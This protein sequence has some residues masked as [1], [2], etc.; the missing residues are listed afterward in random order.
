MA[1][2]QI[3]SLFNIQ[4][5]YVLMGRYS[6]LDRKEVGPGSRLGNHPFADSQVS[7][8]TSET[9]ALPVGT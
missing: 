1:I 5:T 8:Y 4:N 3:H 7:N 2:Y 6:N 9:K